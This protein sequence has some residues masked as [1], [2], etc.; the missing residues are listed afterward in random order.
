MGNRG[1]QDAAQLQ[2]VLGCE[3]GG[4]EEAEVFEV[5]S[6]DCGA[7]SHCRRRKARGWWWSARSALGEK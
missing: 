1:Q 7:A 2:G 6:G 4:D 5:A 3:L